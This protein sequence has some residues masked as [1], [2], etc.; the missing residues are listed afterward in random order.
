MVDIQK[1][2]VRNLVSSVYDIQKLRIATGNRVVQS[3]NVQMGQAP[4]TRQEDMDEE[5]VKLIETLRS[6]YK[7]ITDAYVDKEYSEVLTDGDSTDKRKNKY[8]TKK[9]GKTSIKKSEVAEDKLPNGVDKVEVKVVKLSKNASIDSVIKSMTTNENAGIN[10]IKTKLD[11][12]LIGTYVDLLETEERTLKI[13][14]KEV[15]KHPMWDKF[16]KDVKGCGTLMAAVCI[17]YFDIHKARHVASF[18]KYAGLDTVDVVKEDGAIVNE[19]RASKHAKFTEIEYVDKNGEVKTKH[20]LGYNP[21]LKTKLVG[22]LGSCLL[23]SGLRTV[24]DDKGKPVL[25]ADGNKQ[26]TASSTYVQ[27]YLDYMH[28]LNN[29]VDSNDL[30]AAHKHA[31]ANRYMIK[32]FIRDLWVTWRSYE[33]YEVSKPYEVEKL[34]YKPHKYN[35]YH[36]RVAEQNKKV[37]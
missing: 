19:G 7:R 18:W 31:M 13:L 4:S 25:D 33:G 24:K 29:R 35:E 8:S 30:T 2:K 1:E 6:E 9:V 28:R 16:F 5:T 17:A 22:V 3:F 14:S 20:G 10:M 11:Y 34:G 26:Q 23:K 36:D 27:C 37:V 15:E 12:E 32:M 21:V